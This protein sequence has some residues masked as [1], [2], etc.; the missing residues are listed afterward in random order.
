MPGNTQH[1]VDLLE[2]AVR[3]DAGF[4]LGH[5]AL[6]E[7][8]R[9]RFATE[10][11]PKLLERARSEANAALTLDPDASAAHTALAAIHYAAGRRD[12]AVTSLRRALDLQPDND[13][14]HRLLGQVLAAQGR[15]DEGVTELE[16][17]IRL[18][19]TF[20]NH[21]YTLG[22]VLFTASRYPLALDRF[23][24]A[25]DLRPDHGGAYEMLGATSEMLGD[26]DQAIGHYEHAVRVGPTAT[27]FANLGLAYF[28]AGQ[29]EKAQEAVIAAIARD[30]KKAT[31]HR[32]LGDIHLRLGQR[33]QA[34]Q[35]YER[36]ISLASATLAAN[37]SDPFSIVLIAVCEANLGRRSDA[38]R[39][40]AEATALAPSNRDVLFR[41][42]KVYTLTGNRTAALRALR[43]AIERG[44]ATEL[45]RHDPE[46]ASL[47]SMPEFERVLS[48]EV[49]K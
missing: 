38:E 45:A 10:R 13:E 15:V 1:A 23:R 30:P 2:R 19:P 41:S 17:A 47:R 37:P 11:D 48:K 21:Y 3:A 24:K 40:A 22:F 6:A 5:A 12:A 9:A 18:R 14:A 31:L 49:P 42:A 46:L 33:S 32:D 16:I 34:R 28:T 8:L 26:L 35:A 36:A 44:Y 4:A 20:F 27:A 25:T 7:A 39:H 43:A 29:Y